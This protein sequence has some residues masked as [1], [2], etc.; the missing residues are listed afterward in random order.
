MLRGVCV[1][2]H[3]YAHAGARAH[4]RAHTCGQA[5]AGA[6]AHTYT[7]AHTVGAHTYAVSVDRPQTGENRFISFTP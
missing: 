2:S 1:A 7:H 3:I 6:R 5:R 4:T